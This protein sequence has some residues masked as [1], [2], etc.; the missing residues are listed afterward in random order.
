V[1]HRLTTGSWDG[2]AN[3]ALEAAAD[4]FMI[5]AIT[6]AISGGAK[7]I[8]QN[9]ALK[10]SGMC[11]VSGTQVLTD[12]GHKNIE[13]IEPG[14]IVWSYNEEFDRDEKNVVVQLFR[15]KSDKLTHVVVCD[16]EILCTPGHKFFTKN[17]GWI[18]AQN[19]T[20]DD[21]VMLHG[22][23][24]AFV[25]DVWTEEFE[26]PVTVYNFEVAVAH[27]YFVSERNVLVH[28]MCA[29]AQSSRIEPKFFEKKHGLKPDSYHS[30]IK[31][32]ILKKLII[33]KKCMVQ[34]LIYTWILLVELRLFLV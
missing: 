13:D 7:G 34:T 22:T 21:A 15:N 24:A 32:S 28:N 16:E 1:E 25:K 10:C 9:R 2:A 26:N 20:T 33:M 5:G 6:G 23:F 31:K 8:G 19:L 14:D 12:N 30:K 3:A 27:T 29:K 17:R 18:E 4:G 11:F